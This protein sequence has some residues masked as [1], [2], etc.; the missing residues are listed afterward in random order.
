[1]EYLVNNLR[2]IIV[3]CFVM[4][5]GI[6]SWYYYTSKAPNKEPERADLVYLD[7]QR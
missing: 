7:I 4:I 6:G 2:K 1:M 5:I 3:I